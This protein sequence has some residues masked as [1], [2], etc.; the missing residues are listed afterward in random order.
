MVGDRLDNDIM[1]AKKAGMKTIR[2]KQGLNSVQKPLSDEYSPDW[3][4]TS[5]HQ[6]CDI[7][8]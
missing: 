6:L 3:E 8:K 4:V 5:V 1:P 2:I 7:L